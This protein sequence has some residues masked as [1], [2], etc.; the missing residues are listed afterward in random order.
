VATAKQVEAV[1]EVLS[2][3]GNASA[4]AVEVAEKVLEALERQRKRDYRYVV[5]AQDRSRFTADGLR[6][7]HPTW[8][9]GPYFTAAEAGAVARAERK[10]LAGEVKVMTAQV[11]Q[12]DEQ[13]DPDVLNEVLA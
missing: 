5:I 11:F 6:S 13:V 3:E 2:D 4:S 9:L 1:A 12:P 10:R 8:V 7:F